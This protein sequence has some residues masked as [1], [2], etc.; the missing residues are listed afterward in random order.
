[1]PFEVRD[2]S[3]IPGLPHC[4][5]L[6]SSHAVLT[7]PVDQIGAY[8]LWS[9]RDPAPGSSRSTRPSPLIRRVGAHIVAFEACSSFTRVTAFK[10]ARP[11]EVDFVARFQPNRLPGL[12]ARQL[13]NLTI[14]YSSG[15][16]PHW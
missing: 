1:M 10:V 5:R 4:R 3:T 16:F 7:T 12:T 2:S 6:P 15:S 8:W 13:S 9:W 11:P 14:N